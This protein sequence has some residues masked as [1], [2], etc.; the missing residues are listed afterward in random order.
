MRQFREIYPQH[1]AEFEQ[2]RHDGDSGTQQYPD[3]GGAKPHLLALAVFFLGA[4]GTLPAAPI[5]T[6][7]PTSELG[8]A[9]GWGFSISNDVG[10]IEITSAR[11]CTGQVNFPTLCTPPDLGTFTDFISQFNDIIVGPAG[12]DTSTVAQ[13]FDALDM[14]GIGSFD[15]AAG[16]SGSDVGQI[17]LTYRWTDLEPSDMNAVVLGNDLVLSANASVIVPEP[18]SAGLLLIGGLGMVL[19]RLCKASGVGRN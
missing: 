2:R 4:A 7:L 5:L 12:T 9:P 17:V 14:T 6:L 10:Y 11:F 15:I 3:V 19:L 8:A 16:A 18:A 13:A 1:Q